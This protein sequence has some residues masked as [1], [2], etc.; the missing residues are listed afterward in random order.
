MAPSQIHF[1][2]TTVGAPNLRLSFHFS[3]FFFFNENI[4]DLQCCANFCCTASDVFLHVLYYKCKMCFVFL[5]KLPFAVRKVRRLHC[6]LDLW[7][8]VGFWDQSLGITWELVRNA[9][10]QAAPQTHW[11]RNVGVGLVLCDLFIIYFILF[12]GHLRQMEVPRLGVKSE[13]WLQLQ[14]CGIHSLQES[15]SLNPLSEVRDWT[16]ILTDSMSGS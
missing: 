2:C 13:L 3:F 15:R 6:D 7:V 16:H 12:S 5:F 11:V 4:V 1:C 10:S 14:Q 9:H 8:S